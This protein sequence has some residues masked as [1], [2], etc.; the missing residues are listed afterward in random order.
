M[1]YHVDVTTWFPFWVHL[2]WFISTNVEQ[3]MPLYVHGIVYT[4]ITPMA[5]VRKTMYRNFNRLIPPEASVSLIRQVQPTLLSHCRT[6]SKFPLP[7]RSQPR[8]RH[9]STHDS[10]LVTT[11]LSR[12]FVLHHPDSSSCQ[13]T[14]RTTGIHRECSD[15]MKKQLKFC[16]T[17]QSLC[18]ISWPPILL[19]STNDIISACHDVIS[20]PSLDPMLDRACPSPQTQYQTSKKGL[21]VNLVT[22]AKYGS[23]IG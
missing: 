5:S 17:C 9:S 11:H 1:P 20:G 13:S 22:W 14:N 19:L 10:I 3:P 18:H 21:T 23:L 15:T 2:D 8:A 6:K 7:P 12:R 16:F 4:P